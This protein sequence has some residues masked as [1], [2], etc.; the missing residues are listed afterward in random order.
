[1]RWRHLSLTIAAL[2]EVCTLEC[3]LLAVVVQSIDGSVCGVYH[4]MPMMPS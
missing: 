4:I 2:M 3:S 1:M